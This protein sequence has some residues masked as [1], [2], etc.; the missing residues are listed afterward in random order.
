MITE[1]QIEFKEQYARRGQS[2]S[3]ASSVFSGGLDLNSNITLIFPYGQN[4]EFVKAL[5]LC[6]R[7][8]LE[9][10]HQSTGSLPVTSTTIN[11]HRVITGDDCAP[12][13]STSTHMRRV[14]DI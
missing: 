2:V 8:C 5:M 3:S 13:K 7:L 12:C 1:N 6:L 10:N 4:L 11:S 14:W 9:Q